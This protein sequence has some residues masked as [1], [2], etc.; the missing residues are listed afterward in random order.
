[1]NH[2]SLLRALVLLL[3]GFDCLAAVISAGLLNPYGTAR[4]HID[5]DAWS[6][7]SD[8]L[9]FRAQF[10]DDALFEINV[11]DWRVDTVSRPFVNFGGS[12]Q[13]FHA[14]NVDD[15]QQRFGDIQ[16]SV[17]SP[18]RTK[19]VLMTSTMRPSLFSTLYDENLYIL[20]TR[21][22]EVIFNPYRTE[23]LKRL[24]LPSIFLP[25]ALPVLVYE[26]LSFA[27]ILAG[28]VALYKASPHPRLSMIG[29]TGFGVMFLYVV[30]IAYS[31]RAFP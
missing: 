26:V 6:S 16:A 4:Y 1:M 9:R 31:F 12:V 27:L 2:L 22:Q 29:L 23:L 28:T 14:L 13:Q 18:D 21:T 17:F 15:I 5:Q 25:F 8:R 3:L 20:D 30:S 24:N 11:N 10:P 19:L 7:T